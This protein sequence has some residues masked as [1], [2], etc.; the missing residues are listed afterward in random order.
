MTHSW[1]VFRRG[2]RRTSPYFVLIALWLFVVFLLP[3]EWKLAALLVPLGLIEVALVYSLIMHCG[4][5]K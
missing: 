5:P 4:E 1:P 2:L 3:Y